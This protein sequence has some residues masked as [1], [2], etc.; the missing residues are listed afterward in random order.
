MEFHLR[1]DL[2]KVK[3]HQSILLQQVTVQFQLS[4]DVKELTY[5]LTTKD[6]K[7]FMM[8]HIHQGKAGENGPSVIPLSMGKGEIIPSDLQGSTLSGKQLKRFSKI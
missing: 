1:E 2:V 6:L 4:P 3:Y 5:D 8:A 7:S